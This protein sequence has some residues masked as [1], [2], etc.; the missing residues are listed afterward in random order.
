MF[1]CCL[2]SPHKSLCI[3][4]TL[5]YFVRL[6][7]ICVVVSISAIVRRALEMTVVGV[8]VLSDEVI[9]VKGTM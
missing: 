1:H 3:V 8:S 4:T 2:G 9:N 6:D 7:M 5:L